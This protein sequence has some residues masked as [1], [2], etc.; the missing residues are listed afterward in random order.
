MYEA[1][2]T[3]SHVCPASGID[4]ESVQP[5]M[6]LS[7]VSRM[8]SNHPRTSAHMWLGSSSTSLPNVAL[9]ALYVH[10]IADSHLFSR[11]LLRQLRVLET[12]QVLANNLL[13]QLWAEEP[14]PDIIIALQNIMSCIERQTLLGSEEDTKR[15]VADWRALVTDPTSCM[16]YC[17]AE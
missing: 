9:A 13:P 17:H 10:L 4:I 12:L 5:T 11:S 14:K 3:E 15:F 1:I 2:S 16:L 8:D 7:S 6:Q